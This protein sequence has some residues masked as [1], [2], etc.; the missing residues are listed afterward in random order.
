MKSGCGRDRRGRGIDLP[1]VTNASLV[2]A[3]EE[4]MRAEHYM[5]LSNTTMAFI[6]EYHYLYSTILLFPGSMQCIPNIW[7]CALYSKFFFNVV[8]LQGVHKCSSNKCVP[9]LVV[10]G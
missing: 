6:N 9:W 7:W 5:R 4:A 2:P 8:R 10:F 1:Y 3:S